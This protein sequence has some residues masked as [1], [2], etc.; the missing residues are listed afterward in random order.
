MQFLACLLI[1]YMSIWYS[2][3]VRSR[4]KSNVKKGSNKYKNEGKMPGICQ[5]I[6][7]HPNYDNYKCNF[8]HVY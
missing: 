8:C 4:L 6:I 2:I 5:K 1:S 3:Q 7:L